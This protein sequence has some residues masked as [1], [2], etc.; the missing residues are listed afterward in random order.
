MAG[1]DALGGPR[2]RAE[3]R[4]PFRKPE[5]AETGGDGSWFTQG[6][7]TSEGHD[8]DWPFMIEGPEL[9]AALHSML[10]GTSGDDAAAQPFTRSVEAGN[11]FRCAH[12]PQARRVSWASWGDAA[13][14]RKSK[15]LRG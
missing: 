12:A 1:R 11:E 6:S 7:R 4:K 2:E 3:K 9:G 13:T 15:P 8:V 5:R 14:P 10:D